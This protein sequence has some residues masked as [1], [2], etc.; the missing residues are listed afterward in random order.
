[1][2][3]FNQESKIVSGRC[4]A[5][6]RT[7]NSNVMFLVD[8]PGSMGNPA[9]RWPQNIAAARRKHHVCRATISIQI[10]I[11]K[12]LFSQDRPH[13]QPSSMH[14]RSGKMRLGWPT[15]QRWYF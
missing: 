9:S 3:V 5:E 14:G 15:W 1:M 11:G 6:L 8:T 2:Q 12:W 13:H 4:Q 7:P 10:I